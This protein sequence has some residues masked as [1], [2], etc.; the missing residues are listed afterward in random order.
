LK[1]RLKVRTK[2]GVQSVTTNITEITSLIPDME[3]R[4]VLNN[5]SSGIVLNFMMQLASISYATRALFLGDVHLDSN[6]AVVD[7][8]PAGQSSFLEI[9]VGSGAV[10]EFVWGDV[11]QGIE[12]MSHN[13][14]AALLTLQLGTMSANCSFDHQVVIYQYSSFALWA[15]Y[16]VSNCSFLSCYD[17]TFFPIMFYRRPWPLL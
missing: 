2:G 13:V 4:T 6:V 15:P 16:G 10:P 3:S 12:G 8:R 11:L 9:Q 14:T 7:N 17:L 5:M 1:C